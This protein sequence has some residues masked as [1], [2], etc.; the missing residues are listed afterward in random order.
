LQITEA[1]SLN[2]GTLGK[3]VWNNEFEY[4]DDVI[5]NY[6]FVNTAQSIMNWFVFENSPTWYWLHALKPTTNSESVG[7]GLG[8]WRPWTDTDFNVTHFP[9]VE[10]GHWIYN[11]ANWN[12]VAGFVRYMPWDSVRIDVIESVVAPDARILAYLFEPSKAQ[13]RTGKPAAEDSAPKMGIAVTNRL[14]NFTH[15][16]N[17]TLLNVPAGTTFSGYQ[18]QWNVTNLSLGTQLTSASS[19]GSSSLWFVV[20]PYSIQFWV[21]D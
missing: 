13:W 15:I 1:G 7:Y 21:Q 10:Y 19:E 12:S 16:F 3:P 18:Y 20:P 11:D 17:T 14:G 6:T 8:Y 9:N 5:N 4:L 2:N